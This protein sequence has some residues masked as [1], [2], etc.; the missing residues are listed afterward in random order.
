MSMIVNNKYEFGDL[1]Y[2]KT[3][4]DQELAIITGIKLTPIG[5]VIYTVSKGSRSSE[6]YDFEL[7]AEKN[8]LITSTN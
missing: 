8:I 4:T 6:H 5:N 7:S 1:L 2:L 3:D